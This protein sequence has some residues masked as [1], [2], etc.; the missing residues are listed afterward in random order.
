MIKWP[1]DVYVDRRKLSGCLLEPLPGNSLGW[2]VGVGINVNNPTSHLENAI[3]LCE[4]ENHSLDL[5]ELLIRL[6]PR[7]A[8]AYERCETN[9]DL[10]R[11]EFER[12]DWLRG[13]RVKWCWG[14]EEREG[15]AMGIEP[16]GGLRIVASHQTWVA[17]SGNILPLD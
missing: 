11:Q 12:F 9:Q 15:T 13:R 17:Y 10:L 16:D 14:E 5:S 6:L 1:N 3:S 7:L 2:I 4:L 8:R